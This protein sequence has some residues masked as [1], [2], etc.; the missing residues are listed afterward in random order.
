MV[1]CGSKSV[2]RITETASHD[3]SSFIEGKNIKCY[4]VKVIIEKMATMYK[5]V[6]Y[7][8]RK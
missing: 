6:V 3:F 7:L 4:P 5:Y 1:R 2:Y 8:Y